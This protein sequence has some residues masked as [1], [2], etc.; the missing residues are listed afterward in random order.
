[1][2]D[3]SSAIRVVTNASV[4]IG[5]NMNVS[6]TMST[7][8][9]SG[10]A[11][12]R[13]ITN[14]TVT[15]AAGGTPQRPL[16]IGSRDIGGAPVG[17]V[18]GVA[19]ALGAN[20]MGQLVRYVGR[21]TAK[22]ASSIWVDDGWGVL[23]PVGY[24]GLLVRC[25]TSSPLVAVGDMVIVTGI[26]E[27]SVSSGESANRRQIKMRDYSELIVLTSLTSGTSG[28]SARL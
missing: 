10:V 26:I 22:I 12:E 20:N 19:G 4:T 21:V 5:Q 15:I 13:Q 3:R 27:G 1:E 17:L 14:C 2:V 16:G 28:Q 25:T 18:S 7:R 11:S 6:G 9:V 8:I 24:T 23:D